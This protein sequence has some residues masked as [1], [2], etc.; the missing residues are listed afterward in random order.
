MANVIWLPGK[1]CQGKGILGEIGKYVLPYGRKPF[2]LWEQFLKDAYGDLIVSSFNASGLSFRDAIFK[3]ESTKQAAHE[4]AD[5]IRAEGCDVVIGI[6]GGKAIDTA[7]GAAAFSNTRLVIVPTVASNDA[8]SSACT[9]WYKDD[10]EYDGFDM[11]ATNPDVIIADTEVIA[12]APVRFFVAGMGDALATWP[13]AS[14]CF[15]K[16]AV[17]CTGGVQTITAMAMAKLC[18]DTILEYGVE[19]KSAVDRKIATAAVDKVVE[20]NILLSGVGWESGG[21]ATAHAIA[22]SL[23]MIHETHGLL[24]GEKVSFGLVTQLCLDQNLSVD[25]IYRIVD[26]QVAVGLP[27]TLSDMKMQEV[28]RERLLNFAESVSGEGS[29]V[30]NHPF[31]VTPTDIVDAMFAADSLGARRKKL[32]K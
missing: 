6:G 23:P 16:R 28:S 7:K 27:V 22:N 20:A 5:D 21:L 8:P 11:W 30:Y 10:G 2:I 14:T 32:Q 25:E 1:Y 13:E 4:L 26:F 24:H 17:A 3:G 31:I 9:V 18:F 19:A 29:F 12:K 15:A